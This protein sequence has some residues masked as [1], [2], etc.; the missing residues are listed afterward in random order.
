MYKITI[1]IPVYNTQEFIRNSLLSALNQSYKNIEFL[2]IDD[3]GTDKSMDIVHELI[4]THTRGKDIRIIAHEK[5]KGL[6]EARNTALKEAKG[7]YIFFLDSDDTISSNCIEILYKN[8]IDHSVDFVAASYNKVDEKDKVIEYVIYPSIV[9]KGKNKIAEY[10]FNDLKHENIPTTMWNKLYKLSFLQ[11]N[12]I[13]CIPKRLYEDVIFTFNL[14]LI[15]NSCVI[16]SDLLYNY[17][18]RRNSIMQFNQ[19]H[20][21]P[22]NEIEDHYFYKRIIKNESQKYKKNTFYNSMITRT[23]I[24]CFYDVRAIVEKRKIISEVVSSKNIKDLLA[25]PVSFYEIWR[26]KKH[27]IL[28][29]VLFVFSKLPYWANISLLKSNIKYRKILYKIRVTLINQ[30]KRQPNQIKH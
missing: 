11:E 15:A 9:I 4:R 27:R 30:C 17:K 20:F 10:Y 18:I 19:R 24:S 25:Y 6:A 13:D 2:I 28:N 14:I 22:I 7:E 23:M 29:I 26:F 3:K 21:I 1:G 12:K 5:N 8:I 16:I